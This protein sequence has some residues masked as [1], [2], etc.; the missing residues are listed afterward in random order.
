[1]CYQKDNLSLLNVSIVAGKTHQ[2]RAQLSYAK[3]PILGD[4]KYG[5][6]DIN[7]K[8]KYRYQLL[9]AYKIKFALDKNSQMSYLNDINLELECEFKNLFN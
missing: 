7:K 4:D 1:M 2:I 5:I 9:Q 3:L 8:Y 6:G